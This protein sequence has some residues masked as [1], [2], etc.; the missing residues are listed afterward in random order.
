M[1]STEKTE[2]LLDVERRQLEIQSLRQQVE[3]EKERVRQNF[4]KLQMFLKDRERCLLF[5]LEEIAEKVR[6]ELEENIDGVRELKASRESLEQHLTKNILTDVREQTQRILED[7]IGEV[8]D[9]GLSVG[10]VRVEWNEQAISNICKIITL[11]EKPSKSIKYDFNVPPWWSATQESETEYI[12]PS[13]QIAIGS[14][15]NRVF[16]KDTDSNE[17][18]VFNREGEYI[19][20][21]PWT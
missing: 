17:I 13:L 18:Q 5:E 3:E 9:R 14:S 1:T 16:I 21:H 19:E 11:K 7:Q 6:A 10:W 12:S 4:L 8:V 20:N 2:D 15:S